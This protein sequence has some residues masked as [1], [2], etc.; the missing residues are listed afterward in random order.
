MKAYEK[1]KVLNVLNGLEVIETN[2]G[3]DAYIL[4][5][6][7]SENL[8]KL[9]EVG[10][11][12]ELALKYGDEETFC[13]LALAFGE[14]YADEWED[15]KLIVHYSRFAV[16]NTSTHDVDFYDSYDEALE[17]YEEIKECI[18]EDDVSGDENVYIFEV[19]KVAS[20][21]EDKE[22]EDDPAKHGYDYWVK[23]QDS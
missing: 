4:V 19:K 14:G 23:W 2:G 15:G 20:L 1:Q 9:N 7:S 18:F 22:R 5:A 16:H 8:E 11:S 10:V 6:S 21:V 13:I 12:I 17:A 3:D